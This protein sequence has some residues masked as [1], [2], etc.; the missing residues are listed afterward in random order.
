MA[1]FITHCHQT[2]RLYMVSVIEIY[3]LLFP[4]SLKC[5]NIMFIRY[6][7]LKHAKWIKWCIYNRM[8]LKPFC[9]EDG[10]KLQIHYK[11]IFVH[12]L[13]VFFVCIYGMTISIKYPWRVCV[14]LTGA[15]HRA[16]Y[17]DV[18]RSKQHWL[19]I[20]NWNQLD[21]LPSN[22]I[23]SFCVNSQTLTY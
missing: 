9:I 10:Y 1:S 15:R 22:D 4:V 20:N 19:S 21:N 17:I 16:Y 7:G 11:P 3:V 6:C 2:G 12:T 8:M 5:K 13:R 18:Y 23:F 14:E